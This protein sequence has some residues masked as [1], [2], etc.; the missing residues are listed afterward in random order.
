MD[1]SQY[2]PPMR[3]SQPTTT[4]GTAAYAQT[5]SSSPAL[6][7]SRTSD[8][9][10]ARRHSEMPAASASPYDQSYRRVSNPYEGGYSMPP[11]QSIPSISGLTQS[12]LPSPGMNQTS[13]A[14]MMPQYDTSSMSRSVPSIPRACSSCDGTWL[15]SLQISKHVPVKPIRTVIHY[16]ACQP[17]DVRA[18]SATEHVVPSAFRRQQRE[19][20]HG[21][22][23]GHRLFDT[24]TQ[25][26]T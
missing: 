26:T 15:T 1:Q 21:Q 23:Y 24:S 3:M 18:Q 16:S 2:I 8:A 22:A 7:Q 10:S 17:T 14:Q 11:S 19:R 25:P 12:P 4:S 6:Y 20:G 13:G 9:S 5:S